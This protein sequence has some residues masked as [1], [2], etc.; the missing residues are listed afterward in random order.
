MSTTFFLPT[1]STS[2]FSDLCGDKLILWFVLAPSPQI[3]NGA[4]WMGSGLSITIVIL[5]DRKP[6]TSSFTYSLGIYTWASG[7][8]TN[9]RWLLNQR[10]PSDIGSMVGQRLRCRSDIDTYNMYNGTLDSVLR[11]YGERLIKVRMLIWLLLES[12]K[13]RAITG[14]R[15]TFSVRRLT[16]DVRIWHL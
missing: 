9:K 15:L 11:A 6:S 12:G 10:C 3:S 7:Y 14:I 16:L 2:F 4:S 13:Y 1:F 5:Q 8:S